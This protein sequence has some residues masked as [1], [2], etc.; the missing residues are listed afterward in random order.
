LH[1]RDQGRIRV[2]GSGTQETGMPVEAC[3]LVLMAAP[4]FFPFHTILICILGL[5]SVRQSPSRL[6][7]NR[8]QYSPSQSTRQREGRFLWASCPHLLLTPRPRWTAPRLPSD[9]RVTRRAWPSV[10]LK[11][12]MATE[13]WT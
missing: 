5:L 2:L 13:G 1:R 9:I 4:R 8:L 7:S 10:T 12:S 3:F 6:R 11:I